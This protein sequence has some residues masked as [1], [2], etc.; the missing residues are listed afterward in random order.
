MAQFSTW[1][2]EHR[3]KFMGDES[4]GVFQEWASL[5]GLAYTKY[6]LDRPPF[7]L[8][9]NL[10][11]TVR[12]T[13][14]FLVEVQGKKRRFGHIINKRGAAARHFLVETKGIGKDQIV[15][16]KE[17]DAKALRRWSD[18]QKHPVVFF[19][20]DRQNRRVSINMTLDVARDLSKDAEIGYFNDSAKPKPYYK[21][22]ASWLTWE[23]FEPEGQES[24]T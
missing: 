23:P 19:V 6:G 10:D 16:L 7:E 2:I 4:Q 20:W 22:P 5:N 3:L 18:F 14:D 15:K 12:H 8:F 21:I 17:E 13:P 9:Y 11:S 1:P 24:E